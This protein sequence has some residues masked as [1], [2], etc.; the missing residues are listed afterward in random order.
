MDKITT[1]EEYG[2]ISIHGTCL[3]LRTLP[4]TL[5]LS[6][7]NCRRRTQYDA[8]TCYRYS[9]SPHIKP[10]FREFYKFILYYP[11]FVQC[12]A[13][14]VCLFG[15]KFC[16]DHKLERHT[17]IEKNNRLITVHSYVPTSCVEVLAA[18]FDIRGASNC[19]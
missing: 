17:R 14:I 11:P 15:L 10:A 3:V 7:H 18:L 6:T 8:P 12:V 4:A 1:T 16:V 5:T 9:T 19:G 2:T 13:V